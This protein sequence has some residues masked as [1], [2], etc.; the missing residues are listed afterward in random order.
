MEIPQRFSLHVL[1]LLASCVAQFNA[2]SSDQETNASPSVF[3]SCSDNGTTFQCV[4]DEKCIPL[5]SKCDGIFDCDDNTDELQCYKK[6]DSHQFQCADGHCIDLAWH[7]DGHNDCMD[8]EDSDEKDC[9]APPSVLASSK[10][11][12]T[13]NPRVMGKLDLDFTA[14]GDVHTIVEWD[15][16]VSQDWKQWDKKLGGEEGKDDESE[17]SQKWKPWVLPKMKISGEVHGSFAKPHSEERKPRV[18][19]EKKLDGGDPLVAQNLTSDLGASCSCGKVLLSSLGPAANFQPQAMGTYTMAYTSY[20]NHPS[21]RQNYGRD[22]RLYFAPTGW[23]IGDN[24]GA[25]TGYIHNA[26]HSQVCP[27]TIPSGWMFYSTQHGAWYP[28]TSLVL[29]CIT[30]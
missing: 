11:I 24:R 23:L 21:Y 13:T 2:I 3:V 5:A 9:P 17:G 10:T 25:P 27:Y 7:C 1:L 16:E 15:N 20:N 14:S 22:F 26:D 4:K 8:E 28:D 6:C 19:P 12:F 30:P 29:R 18:L